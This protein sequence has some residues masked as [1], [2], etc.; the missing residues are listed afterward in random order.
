L[1]SLMITLALND[2]L[3]Y[4]EEIIQTLVNSF[5]LASTYGIAPKI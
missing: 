3:K 2:I 4:K 1:I 5:R